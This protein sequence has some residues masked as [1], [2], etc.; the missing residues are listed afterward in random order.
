MNK[1]FE[2]VACVLIVWFSVFCILDCVARFEPAK[3]CSHP[4]TVLYVFYFNPQVV[5]IM[6]NENLSWWHW[7]EYGFPELSL[8]YFM[9]FVWF[10]P[11]M[12]DDYVGLS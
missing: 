1:T 2:A 4:H 3:F 6:C 12:I 8:S 7:T 10:T 9:K 5:D 11:V